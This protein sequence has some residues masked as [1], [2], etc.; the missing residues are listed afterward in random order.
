MRWMKFWINGSNNQFHVILNVFG[1]K[2]NLTEPTKHWLVTGGEA[3]ASISSPV[4]EK[5]VSDPVCPTRSSV[6]CSE[7]LCASRL[8]SLTNTQWLSLEARFVSTACRHTDTHRVSNWLHTVERRSAGHDGGFHRVVD[9]RFNW[10]A[11]ISARS[12]SVGLCCRLRF[13]KFTSRTSA[14]H[15]HALISHLRITYRHDGVV[16]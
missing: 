9:F 3:E 12:C 5:T 13:G 10:A 2:E 16:R 7:C 1:T 14:E 11:A 4:V 15:F 8:T 6:R